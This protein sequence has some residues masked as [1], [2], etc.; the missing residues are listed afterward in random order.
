MDKQKL[1]KVADYAMTTSLCVLLFLC[2]CFPA[3]SQLVKIPFLGLVCLAGLYE[4]FKS[5][6]KVITKQIWFWMLLY[7]IYN[8]IWSVLGFANEQP[9]ASSYFRLGVIWP[10]VFLLIIATIDRNRIQW[11]DRVIFIIL[12]FQVVA[13]V[14]MIGYGFQWWPNLL[15]WIFPTSRV[16]IHLGYIHVTGHFIGGMAFTVP[17]VYSRFVIDKPQRN[18]MNAVYLTVW[19]V[20]IMALVATSRRILLVLVVICALATIIVALLRKEDR[21]RMI[22]RSVCGLMI[23]IVFIG[24]T[25]IL[26]SNL[27]TNFL[28]KNYDEIYETTFEHHHDASGKIKNVENVVFNLAGTQKYIEMFGQEKV[29]VTEPNTEPNNVPST[30]TEPNSS[31]NPVTSPTEPSTLAPFVDRINSMLGELTG[32]SV[33]GRIIN[34]A[35]KGWTES[36]VFGVGFGAQLPGYEKNASVGI[37]EMEFVVRLYTTGIVGLLFLLGLMLYVGIAGINQMRKAL[38]SLRMIA[39][40]IVSYLGAAV[41]TVSNPYIFSGFDYLFMLFLPVAFLNCAIREQEEKE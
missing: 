32:D 30:E 23:T 20:V 4:L 37:Y 39:P 21:K 38:S 28:N 19:F 25:V 8:L 24:C 35:L 34:G 41:A 10:V 12:S 29:P 18:C 27:A 11:L 17:Y 7:W 5:R 40:C 3:Q 22:V 14:L 31:T 33:R 6:G 15:R 16:G 26:T 9:A 2:F 13:V 1:I 36:P